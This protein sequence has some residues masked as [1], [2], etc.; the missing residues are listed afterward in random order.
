[1][2]SLPPP[3]VPTA[4]APLGTGL[5]AKIL[6]KRRIR[7]QMIRTVFA[8]MLREIATTYGRSAGGYLWA[9]AEPVAGVAL[10]TFVFSLTLMRPA[11][12]DNF[13]M[14]YATGLL[15][16]TFYFDLSQR[17]SGAIRF[18]RP[19]LAYPTVSY[20]EALIARLLLNVVT[21]VTIYGIIFIGIDKIYGLNTPWKLE[22]LAMSILIT[23]I[24]AAGIGTLNC[25]LTMEFPVW[26]RIWSILSRPMFLISG[27]F[28]TYEMMPSAAK[29]VLWW[30]PLIHSV[31]LTRDAAYGSYDASY[32]SPLYV[33]TVGMVTL[34][35]GL[36]LLSRHYRRLL[37]N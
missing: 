18:S 10:L 35:F 34:F 12:G 27:V 9:I 6:R 36:L 19:L 15:P 32:V 8:L 21:N 20:S 25:Y 5:R 2:T 37:E 3:T 7:F 23:T 13:A 17:L 29:A 30:N 16:F 22:P 4:A 28:F 14:F 31:A 26:E 11:L 24:L 33:V 1:M